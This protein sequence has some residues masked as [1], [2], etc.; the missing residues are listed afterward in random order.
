MREISEGRPS[1]NTPLAQDGK[2]RVR[3]VGR[4]LNQPTSISED[5]RGASALK[6]Q[7]QVAWITGPT[8][9]SAIAVAMLGNHWQTM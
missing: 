1:A 3:I 9:A 8:E 7:T 4:C 5:A 6:T 2:H